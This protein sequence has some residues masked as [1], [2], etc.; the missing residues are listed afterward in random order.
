MMHWWS[1][2]YCN[3]IHVVSHHLISLIQYTRAMAL[4]KIQS[5]KTSFR[6]NIHTNKYDTHYRSSLH[7]INT[8]SLRINCGFAN[9][10]KSNMHHKYTMNTI[11]NW[12]R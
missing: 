5:Q 8:A 11:K 2:K 3:G 9:H 1:D 7:Y 4:S 12:H 10:S 6:T